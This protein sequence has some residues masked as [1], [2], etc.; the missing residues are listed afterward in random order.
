MTRFLPRLITL[1]VI[2]TVSFEVVAQNYPNRPVTIVVPFPPGNSSDVI[3]RAMAR[4]LQ[5]LLG[6]PVII[7]NRPG[8]GGAIGASYVS[9]QPPDGYTLLNGSPGPMVINPTLRSNVGY[10][11]VQNFEPIAPVANL[12]FVI[13]VGAD[14]PV[15]DLAGLIAMAKKDPDAVRY[16]SS[17]VGSTQHLV[18]ALLASQAEV[19]MMHI[20]FSGVGAGMTAIIGGHIGGEL[21]VIADVLGTLRPMLDS[22]KLV[23]I[24]VT[25]RDRLSTLPNVPTVME[26]GIPD[27][28]VQTWIVVYTSAGIAPPLAER[29]N[30]DIG[31]ALSSPAVKKLFEDQSMLPVTMPFKDLKGFVSRESEV[32]RKLVH[33]S[34]AKLE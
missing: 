16:A 24:A 12:P 28:D 33:V 21:G 30:T 5:P 2:G 34:G 3:M 18:M 31:R 23:P 14:S 13:A 22:G 8:A 11:P 19:K 7:E 29:L 15:K 6:Q 26:Q 20:P 9:R 17:G 27:F 32:W 25:T 1:A 10:D 4:E